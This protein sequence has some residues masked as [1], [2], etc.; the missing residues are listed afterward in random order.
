MAQGLAGTRADPNSEWLYTLDELKELK[1]LM[2]S[3][4][5]SPRIRE[6]ILTLG[7]LGPFLYGW[8]EMS[9]VETVKSWAANVSEND[10]SFL[11]LLLAL[12]HLSIGSKVEYPLSKESIEFLFDFKE[13][14]DRL[15][16]LHSSDALIVKQAMKLARPI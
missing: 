5:N 2:V 4:L 11:K 7:Q 15:E 1:E 8:A 9:G 10:D 16:T 3:E 6:T 13:V 14:K 12:R